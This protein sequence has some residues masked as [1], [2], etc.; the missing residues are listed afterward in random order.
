[1]ENEFSRLQM[2]IGPAKMQKL[3]KAKVAL[4]GVGGVGGYA[5]EALVRSA[6]GNI[7][8]IDHDD[9]SLTNLNRQLVSNIN[10][11]GNS[12]VEEYKERALSINKDINIVAS[13][14]YITKD[15]IEEYI[16]KDVDY[17][18][19]AIDTV[20]SKLQLISFAKEN[21][22]PCISCM[23]TGNKLNP[24]MLEVTDISKTSMCPLAKVVRKE[25]RNMGINHLKV[26][27]SKEEPIKPLEMLDKSCKAGSAAFV[28]AAAGLIIS[29]EV[30]KDLVAIED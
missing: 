15:N 17:I 18:I 29:S 27:Y 6:V 14:I 9:I 16:P 8:I 1:M 28:P 7:Y 5:L 22:I 26:V 13:K 12:K 23:G 10:N 3:A 24:C 30:V 20:T 19:D 25:L 2:L 21:N 4:V 11:I